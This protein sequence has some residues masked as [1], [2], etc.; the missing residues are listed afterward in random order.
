MNFIQQH[1]NQKIYLNAFKQ[2]EK[3]GILLIQ[4]QEDIIILMLKVYGNIMVLIH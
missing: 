2:E 4:W 1:V 3:T